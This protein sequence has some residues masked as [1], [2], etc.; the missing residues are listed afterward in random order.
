MAKT[1]TTTRSGSTAPAG[2]AVGRGLRGEAPPASLPGGIQLDTSAPGPEHRSFPRARLRVPF[3]V[4]IGEGADRRFSATLGSENLSVS[5]AFLE[6]TFFLRVGTEIMVRFELEPKGPPVEARAE[7]LRQ[8]RTEERTGRSGMGLRF[9]EFFKQTEVTLARLFLGEQ[10][11]RFAEG[12]LQTARTRAIES[13]LDRVVD[14]LA[15][16]ELLKV[17]APADPWRIGEALPAPKG[18]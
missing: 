14:A 18:R 10:L 6:S 16:W 7:V 5:G 2:P 13:E 8:E 17:T 11:R 9:L 12:Y 4:W 15:A 1:T 3:R